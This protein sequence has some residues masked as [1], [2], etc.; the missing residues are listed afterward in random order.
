L[1]LIVAVSVLSFCAVVNSSWNA[2][3][4]SALYLAL[5][6]SLAAGT[7]YV[8]N[9]EPHTFVPP[10]FPA[11][12][13]I[14]AWLFGP[15]FLIYRLFMACVGL[16]TAWAGYAFIRRLCGRDTALMVGG[17]FAVN[18]TLLYNCTFVLSDV[19]FALF[20]LIALHAVLSAGRTERFPL[21]WAAIAGLAV[22]LLPLMRING[23]GVPPAAAFFLFCSSHRLTWQKR[24][25]FMGVFLAIAVLPFAAWEWWKAT[26]PVSH[27]E[28]GYYRAI[29]GRSVGDQVR[30]I[31]SA[32]WGYFPE[33]SEALTG[34]RIKTGFLELAAPLLAAVGMVSAFRNGDRL[35]VPVTAVQ[36][37]GLLLSSPGS[38][39]L[40]GLIPA[41]YLFLALGILDVVSWLAKRVVMRALP[42]SILV[43]C[44][45]AMALCNVGH[46]TITIAKARTALETNGAEST[47]SL[48]FFTA[49][50]WLKAHA[51][52]ATVLTTRSRIIHY[53]SG[54]QTVSL[55]RSGVPEK[56]AWVDRPDEI[57]QLIDQ[58]NPQFLYTDGSKADLYDK[59]IHE[60]T[61]MGMK[62]EPVP[63]AS[64]SDRYRLYRIKAPEAP[65]QPASSPASS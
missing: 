6:E 41:L 27:A 33:M 37:C 7:G 62:V 11:L 51:P 39:Y 54:C 43:I 53:L 12:L 5:G 10:G 64:A 56:D 32:L 34:L 58:Y 9:G 21:A 13:A 40:I 50:R 47:R 59:V 26:F 16:L 25:L 14:V 28:G 44:F 17:L 45:A 15:H 19:P 52:H 46:N 22:G 49:A 42:G 1:L 23:L 4:D 65:K 35:L 57:K 55:L 29:A 31:A 60:L 38:R 48:P 36:L 30:V 20:T 18:H 2:T 8:F 63:G 3:P 24:L 61:N